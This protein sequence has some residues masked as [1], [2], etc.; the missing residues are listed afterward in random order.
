MLW[1]LPILSTNISY[2]YI[3]V[4]VCTIHRVQYLHEQ[5]VYHGDIHLGN[6][7]FDDSGML[8][9]VDLGSANKVTQ[10]AKS[11]SAV[12]IA[13]EFQ[14]LDQQRNVNLARADGKTTNNTHRVYS[15]LY[16]LLTRSVV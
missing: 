9:L 15:V 6:I 14:P 4:R 5:D 8:C 10:Y 1:W 16:V 12:F 13:P 3:C 11:Y 7:M 2:T